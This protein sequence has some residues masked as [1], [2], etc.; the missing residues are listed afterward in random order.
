M[1][2]KLSV[3]RMQVLQMPSTLYFRKVNRC[4]AALAP[5]INLAQGLLFI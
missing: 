1:S 3:G 2:L 5:G 4:A